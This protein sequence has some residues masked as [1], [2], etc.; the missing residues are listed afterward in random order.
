[1]TIF[2]P[3]P[4]HE[5]QLLPPEVQAV[6]PI[7]TCLN[8]GR[9]MRQPDGTPNDLYPSEHCG[10]CPPWRC[11]TCG[12]MSDTENLCSCW[13]SLEDTPLADVKALF[14]ADGTFNIGGLGAHH[15]EDGS[16]V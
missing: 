3:V 1:M 4:G 16:D 9:T 6:T 12:E 2:M 7:L 8:C 10:Q 15:R 13:I 5:W 14:A 11:E